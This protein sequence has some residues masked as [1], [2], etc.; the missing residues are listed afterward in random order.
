MISSRDITMLEKPVE[1]R[2]NLFVAQCKREGIDVLIISTY[3]DYESQKA[4]YAQG[5]TI[6]GPKVTNAMEGHSF[7]N[8][9]CAFDF[10]PMMNGKCAWEDDVLFDKCGVIAKSVGLEWAG[11]WTSFKEKGHCQYTGGLSLE[12]LRAGSRVTV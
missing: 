11:D 5:R 8:F 2:C 9:R 6:P 10:V 12:Q 3:R 1:L 4:L 7:H